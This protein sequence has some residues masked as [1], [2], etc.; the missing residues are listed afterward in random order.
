MQWPSSWLPHHRCT[1]VANIHIICKGEQPID[2]LGKTEARADLRPRV[3][4]PNSN[5]GYM[6]FQLIHEALI[7]ILFNQ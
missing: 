1:G 3:L 7:R 2:C 5:P 4:S 6:L